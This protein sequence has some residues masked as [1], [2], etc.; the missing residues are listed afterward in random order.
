MVS[1]NT[2]LS[3]IIA[4]RSMTKSTNLLNQAIERMSTGYKI[5]HAADN[6]AN[7]SISQN[8]NSQMSSY[9]IAADNISMGMDLLQTAQDTIAGMQDRGSRLQSILT[10]ARNGTYGASSLAAMTSEAN[11]LVSEINRLYINT[12]YNGKKL[13]EIPLPDWAKEVKANAGLEEGVNPGEGAGIAAGEVVGLNGACGLSGACGLTSDISPIH[14][15]FIDEVVCDTPEVTIYNPADLANAISTKTIIGIGN[16]ETLAE[17]ANLVNGTS[18]YA[19]GAKNCL[20][21]TIVL[22]DNVDLSAICAAN[23]DP[24]GNGGWNPIGT[25]EYMFKGIFN[26]NGHKVRGLY[27]KREEAFAQGLFGDVTNCQIK[28]LGVEDV[29]IQT[30]D[31]DSIGSLLGEAYANA[32][33][34]NCY[35]TGSVVGTGYVGGLVGLSD[36]SFTSCYSTVNVKGSSSVGGLAGGTEGGVSA[37]NC[38]ATGNVEGRSYIGG[39]IGENGLITNCYATGNVTGTE[40]G[41]GGLVGGTSDA[42][43]NSYATGTVTGAQYTGGLAGYTNNNSTITNSYAT[44]NVTGT[45]YTGGLVGEASKAITNSYATGDVSGTKYVGGLAGQTYSTT[46]KV[47]NSYATGNVRATDERTGGLVGWA[48]GE[49]ENCYALGRVFSDKNYTGGLVGYAEK[50]ISNSYATGT[51]TGTQ[52]TGGLTGFANSTITNSYATGNVTGARFTGGLAGY[53]VKAIINSYATG[54]IIGQDDTGGLTGY[55][56]EAITKSYATGN[57]IGQDCTGGLVGSAHKAIT[58]SYATGNIIGQD[59]T[60]GLAG[61]TNSPIT[62]SY[63]TGKVI[64]AEHTGGLAGSTNNCAITKSYATGN[65]TGTQYTGGLVGFG[66]SNSSITN[67]HAAGNV[68]GTNCAGGLAGLI[69]SAITNSYATG[70]VSGTELVGGLVGKLS[71]SAGTFTHNQILSGGQVRGSDYVG[72]LIGGIIDTS[73]GSNFA[74]IN[75]TNASA[76]SGMDMIGFEGN[77]DGHPYSSGQMETWLENI[78]GMMLDTSLQVG[79]Y[80][81]SSSQIVVDTI[82]NYNLNISDI[83][84]DSAFNSVTEFLNKLNTKATELGAAQNRLESALE[85]TLVS[86]DNLTSSLSTIRDADMAKV[87]SQYIRQ[88]ILQQAAA[89]LMSTANQT[90]AIALQLL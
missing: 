39:L 88:Q 51:V 50:A 80:G 30:T 89:T 67:S 87:S 29:Y 65:V 55:A 83:T 90:P 27:I 13:Y 38:Y 3:S 76:R 57:I 61:S 68:T 64:G 72:S 81:D 56:V 9:D 85:S 71:Q 25:W 60:G 23:T 37:T 58:N 2:N 22:M 49:I 40:W 36:V 46:A 34:T 41:T 26:G 47:S 6:A 66:A 10:Q 48:K 84:S 75:I 16:A 24:D 79:I 59:D 53:S 17:L 82:F 73:D 28:N 86:M 69:T 5:S 35:A 77:S 14:N 45:Q 7:Y 15:G 31:S 63:A 19:S 8:I 20:G 43:S 18:T 78:T 70:N 32:T 4:Q 44:G 52:H 62:N 12:E 21:K 54:N 11:A 42:I 74:T 1:I 33:I